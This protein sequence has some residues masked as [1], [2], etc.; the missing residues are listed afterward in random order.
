MRMLTEEM[1]KTGAALVQL[2]HEHRFS[3]RAA[4][5]LYISEGRRWRL[6]LAI[7][8][9][10][11]EGRGKFY[12]IIYSL[13]KKGPEF[14]YFSLGLVD[15]KKFVAGRIK[16]EDMARYECSSGTVNGHDFDDAYFYPLPDTPRRKRRKA[17]AVG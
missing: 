1:I 17:S 2:L 12:D 6:Y 4:G 14:P 9:V 11:A 10:R 8:G 16:A 3:F 5:W 15:A 7:P 13:M